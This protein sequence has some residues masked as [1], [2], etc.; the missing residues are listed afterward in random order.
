M[1]V[2]EKYKS[3]PAWIEYANGF[4]ARVARANKRLS[5]V[6]KRPNRSLA[7]KWLR[8]YGRDSGKSRFIVQDVPAGRYHK[9]GADAFHQLQQLGVAELVYQKTC[10]HTDTRTRREERERRTEW[11]SETRTY[12]R[13]SYTVAITTCKRCKLTTAE[14]VTEIGEGHTILPEIWDEHEWWPVWDPVPW[15][16]WRLVNQYGESKRNVDGHVVRFKDS[17]GAVRRVAA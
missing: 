5:S 17:P 1:I 13:E 9:S 3:D 2:P 12:D 7:G 8:Y 6:S 10:P 16:P 15:R 11:N 14:E 4:E